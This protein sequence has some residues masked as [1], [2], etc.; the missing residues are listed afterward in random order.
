MSFTKNQA[1]TADVLLEYDKSVE[2]LQSPV[3]CR[4]KSVA[5]DR[6]T[7]EAQAQQ[8]F[9][10]DLSD[11]RI[12]TERGVLPDFKLFHEGSHQPPTLPRRRPTLT[13]PRL[14]L[15][16]K[17]RW[18][19]HSSKCS[20]TEEMTDVTLLNDLGTAPLTG[21]LSAEQGDSNDEVP[22]VHLL[23]RRTRNQMERLF[24]LAAGEIQ[25]PS[26]SDSSNENDVKDDDLTEIHA[27]VA[28]DQLR[29]EQQRSGVLSMPRR[30]S[31]A[32]QLLSLRRTDA[33]EQKPPK[34]PR[35]RSSTDE[36]L[37][38]PVHQ[39]RGITEGEPRA[40]ML[41]DK[42]RPFL[43]RR[44]SSIVR[45]VAQRFVQDIATDDNEAK[46]HVVAADVQRKE[47]VTLSLGT[48]EMLT[49]MSQGR[50]QSDCILSTQPVE[51]LPCR[52]NANKNQCS[53]ALDNEGPSSSSAL[54]H[55]L[56]NDD[57]R[58]AFA[59]KAERHKLQLLQSV[60]RVDF[61]CLNTVVEGEIENSRFFDEVSSPL[62][63]VEDS[64]NESR[65]SLEKPIEVILERD[66][67][68]PAT[69]ASAPSSKASSRA[70]LGQMVIKRLQNSRS[71]R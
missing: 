52:F 63:L 16:E 57:H 6:E 53:V 25:D 47:S 40:E 5:Q 59:S 65:T 1:H 39:V 33:M 51:T 56:S 43:L 68:S 34:Q 28:H 14:S 45:L 36:T 42:T 62:S 10:S 69:M 46:S 70:R 18:R 58:D 15:L 54:K 48:Q 2:D 35:R 29:H 66:P 30:K 38:V 19:R 41:T 11:P 27:M 31:S 9:L 61:A 4:E 24:G 50:H 21:T 49:D 60:E 64:T 55:C 26:E 3:E 37:K 44:Q 20:S 67:R 17:M 12:E 71:N 8:S 23:R 13:K 7:F 32:L 22:R